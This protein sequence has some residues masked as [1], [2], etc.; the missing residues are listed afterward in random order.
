MKHE[1]ISRLY[2]KGVPK[3]P[4]PSIRRNFDLPGV[5]GSFSA[6]LKHRK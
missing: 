6:Q 2:G 3:V 4:L 1:L 5:E